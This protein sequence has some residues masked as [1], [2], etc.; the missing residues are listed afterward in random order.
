MVGNKLWAKFF[1]TLRLSFK[2][3]SRDSISINLLE[4]VYQECSVTVKELVASATSVAEWWDHK[5]YCDSAKAHILE[6]HCNRL[7]YLIMASVLLLGAESHTGQYI[8]YLLKK[9]VDDNGPLKVLG[10]CTYNASNMKKAWE[11]L[12]LEYPHIKPYGCMAHTLQLIFTDLKKIKSAEN[13]Q[14][15]CIKV[16]KAVKQSQKL[17]ALLKQHQQQ[18]PQ[19]QQQ[20]LKLPVKTR[21]GSVI[22]CLKSVCINK[23]ELQALAIND[24]AKPSLDLS[25][26]KLLLS[27]VF[28]D[29]TEGI[30]KLLKPV[31]DAITS[32][33]GDNK[34][35]SLVIKVFSDLKLSFEEN[36]SSFQILKS[37]EEASKGIIRERKKFVIKSIHLAANLVDP[38]YCGCHLS[39]E[40]APFVRGAVDKTSASSWWNGICCS[41]QLSRVAS[42]ILQLPLSSASVERSFSRHALV[43]SARRNCLIT[44]RTA[45]L[46]FIGQNLALGNRDDAHEY[47][48]HAA[49]ASNP[50]R[51]QLS[52]SRDSTASS[53]IPTFQLESD[54]SDHSEADSEDSID[55]LPSPCPRVMISSDIEEP[56]EERQ[57]PHDM[58]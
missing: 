11:L 30:L 25:I 20:T 24:D 22:Q 21:W 36:L 47:P 37:E 29:R 31:A 28:W 49:H 55:D 12:Q 23:H 4:R 1:K 26:R 18:S 35:L 32:I 9:V 46:V 5:L 10:V 13:I 34:N 19:G 17:T 8:A 2:I 27:E 48:R 57:E 38:C 16:C 42:N 33:E 56:E 43:Y 53:S 40:E 6:Q 45:K 15:D 44:D 50:P 54:D 7:Q 3:P 14:S 39:G 58:E 41:T 52:T 51:P